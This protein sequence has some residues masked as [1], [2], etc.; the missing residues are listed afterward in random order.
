[1][2]PDDDVQKDAYGLILDA[3]DQGIYRPG[4]RL[5]ESELADR[6]G[7]SR[8]PIREALAMLA[9]SMAGAVVGTKEKTLT[10][11]PCVIQVANAVSIVA[12]TVA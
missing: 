7:V 12:L 8:T 6:F 2:K 1:M 10:C 3:I 11:A 9:K 5:V 4:D